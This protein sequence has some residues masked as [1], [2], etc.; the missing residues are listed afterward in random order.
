MITQPRPTREVVP[1][2]ATRRPSSRRQT[3]CP[4]RPDAIVKANS[5]V[6]LAKP[7]LATADPA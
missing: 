6:R 2:T 1:P 4:T 5:D 7:Q 3:S